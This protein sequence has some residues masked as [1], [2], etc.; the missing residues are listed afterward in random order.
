MPRGITPR[1]APST[2]YGVLGTTVYSDIVQGATQL[3]GIVNQG[4]RDVA[5]AEFRAEGLALER[6]DRQFRED[7]AFLN[8]GL[9][10]QAMEVDQN[11]LKLQQEEIEIRRQEIQ[12]RGEAL[13]VDRTIALDRNKLAK[14]EVF[15][16]AAAQGVQLPDNYLEGF[17]QGE[18]SHVMGVAAQSQYVDGTQNFLEQNFVEGHGK[19]FTGAGVQEYE[20]VLRKATG[21][22]SLKLTVGD[23][24]MMM[25]VDKKDYQNIPESMKR[26]FAQQ[27]SPVSSDPEAEGGA[28]AI[29][30]DMLGQHLGE[31][32]SAFQSMGRL[33]RTAG[34][35]RMQIYRS[36][37][38]TSAPA[39]Q[40]YIQKQRLVTQN[41]GSS[42]VQTAVEKVQT[43]ATRQKAMR[44]SN[45]TAINRATLKTT[46]E[47]QQAQAEFQDEVDKARTD[48]DMIAAKNKLDTAITAAQASYDT[49]AEDEQGWSVFEETITLGK[50]N[51]SFNN[52]AYAGNW[53]TGGKMK[54]AKANSAQTIM[55]FSGQF[56]HEAYE[57]YVKKQAALLM[58]ANPGLKL[59]Q[60]TD[61]ATRDFERVKAQFEQDLGIAMN[62]GTTLNSRSLDFM[63]SNTKEMLRLLKLHRVPSFI[64][65]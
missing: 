46:T 23:G 51:G 47:I 4:K 6:E 27:G 55:A 41:A 43:Q 65:E 19:E 44:N 22:D 64:E 33:G 42:R 5:E 35:R 14:A 52:T 37:P 10:Q 20:G 29:T 28:V 17:A 1:V 16:N 13:D 57:P 18:A 12:Q 34:E 50:E 9:Q 62:A 15:I 54:D 32:I 63:K 8:R 61:Q 60:A 25:S 36:Q 40:R 24:V 30:P 11:R 7:E 31:E 56:Q 48:E 53:I 39:Q 58:A 2:T 38:G 59:T 45:P 49:R 3:M 21:A 26:L